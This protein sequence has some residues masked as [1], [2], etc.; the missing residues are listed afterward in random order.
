LVHLST[1][2][3]QVK[4]KIVDVLINTLRLQLA[5]SLAKDVVNVHE[6]ILICGFMIYG[7]VVINSYQT[8]LISF[9]ASP[10]YQPDFQTL[11]ELNRTTL[12]L[13]APYG[14]LRYIGSIMNMSMVNQM[15]ETNTTIWELKNSR[16]V[17]TDFSYLTTDRV[18]SFFLTTTLNIQNHRPLLHMV[19]EGIMFAPA[20]YRVA[21][22]SPYEEIISN[23]ISR[24]RAAGLYRKFNW[25]SFYEAERDQLL[26]TEPPIDNA[27]DEEST[28][29]VFS[30]ILPAFLILGC[31]CAIASIVFAGELVYYR[32]MKVGKEKFVWRVRACSHC[33]VPRLAKPHQPME[34][35]VKIDLPWVD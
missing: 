20:S 6:R 14:I 35:E 25:D 9:L 12:N 5:I 15:Y 8:L 4:P 24:F 3:G 30:E 23:W 34:S 29:L 18:A 22:N 32:I 21:R 10:R 13:Y 26:E 33:G 19:A 17:S 7:F 1:F 31:G 16:L 11:A 27:L 2:F 28:R